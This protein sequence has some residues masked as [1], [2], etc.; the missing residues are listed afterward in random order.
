LHS[1]A[2]WNLLHETVIGSS[3]PQ[4]AHSGTLIAVAAPHIND[5][6]CVR[7]TG[8]SAMKNAPAI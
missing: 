7:C 5:P 3:P 4:P 8:T 6:F 2:Y 1:A